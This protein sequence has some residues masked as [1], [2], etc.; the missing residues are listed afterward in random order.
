MVKLQNRSLSEFV[1][2]SALGLVVL[3][4]TPYSVIDAV[5]LPKLSI[6]GIYGFL[7]LG[8]IG[9]TISRVHLR[10]NRT[11]IQIVILFIFDLAL[12][13]VNSGRN[14][15]EGFYGIFGRNTGILAYFSFALLMLLA[16]FSSTRYLLS[17]FRYILLSLGTIL[18]IYGY[19]QYFGLDPFPFENTS[20]SQVFGTFGNSN[21]QS[22]FLGIFAAYFFVFCYAPQVS[23]WIRVIGFVV[24]ISSLIGI[25][26]TQSWQGYFNFSIGA[27]VSLILFVSVLKKKILTTFLI[28]MGFICTF[29]LGLGLLNLG[30]LSGLLVKS[31]LVA[32]RIYWDT[33]IRI[34]VDRP[35]FGVGLDGYGDWFRRGRSAESAS[36]NGNFLSDTAHSVPLD[37]AS[38]GGL[39]LFLLY[40][41]I[42]LVTISAIVRV[43]RTHKE[44]DL[45]FIALCSGWVAYQAQSLISINQ[46]GLGVIGW[47]MAGLIIGYEKK[48]ESNND[49]DFKP[50]LE[51]KAKSI[52]TKANVK[53]NHWRTFVL[54]VSLIIGVAVSIPPFTSAAKF[55]NGLGSSDARIVNTNAYLRPLEQRRMIISANILERNKFHKESLAIARKVTQSFPDSF[56][57]WTFLNTLTYATDEDRVAAARALRR[58]NPRLP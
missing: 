47:I 33:A 18:T 6:L 4:V 50:R 8:V 22:S 43:V 34:T 27:F 36:T 35:I 39:P 2:F 25:Y 15:T 1:L 54:L 58:L 38:G 12:I 29:L 45:N 49:S 16:V 56:E 5:N 24:I 17:H 51:N 19:V 20:A 52:Y 48:L 37:I 28:S 42:I 23:K 44:I 40:L 9:F 3:V 31:S 10:R 53:S 46:L 13:L 26:Q 7:A 32:R 11:I 57:A 30:P 55:Y 41:L 14:I 21:F